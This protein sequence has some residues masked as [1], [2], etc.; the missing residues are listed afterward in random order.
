MSKHQQPSM[1]TMGLIGLGATALGTT[2][3]PD[4][5]FG[6]SLFGQTY[7]YGYDG[8]SETML[9]FLRLAVIAGW[10]GVGFAIGWFISPQAKELRKM[11]L[12]IAVAVAGLVVFFNNGFLGWSLSGFLGLAGFCIG[13]GY[14]LGQT[15]QALGQ[16]PTTFGSAEWAKPEELEE[17]GVFGSEGI[18]LGEANDGEAM[19]P[20]AY[21]GDRHLLTVAPARTG[22]GTSQ[23]VPNLL[24][25][26]GSCVVIDPK[27]ENAMMTAQ[28]RRDMGQQVHLLD[29]WGIAEIEGFEPSRF[30]PMDWLDPGD[31]E[32]TENAMILGDAQIIPSGSAETF[33][34]EE[35]KA[36][37]LGI[38]LYVAT[39][40][41]EAGQRHLGRA[42][43]LMLLDGEDLK[44]LFE[45]MLESPHHIVASTGA[46]AL[47][48]E[49]KLLSNV[50]AS[51]QAQTH[52][53]DSAA[54][55][56]S[57]SVSDF[58]FEDLKTQPMTVYLILPA[59]R[60]NAF[61]RWLR[62]MIQQA[63]TV[64]ARNITDKPDKPVLFILDE[65]AALG[66]LTM[67]EQAY[68]LMAGFGMQLHGVVQD[69][70]QLKRIYGD[71]WETFVGNSGV[72]QYFG[73]RDRMSAEYF[74][75]L[76]G[77]TT[78]WNLS[79]AL[80]RTFSSSSGN[81]GGS[82]SVGN[83][84]TTAAAQRK[85]A[86]PDELMR[87]PKVQQIIFIENMN[88]IVATKVPWFEDDHLKQ[89]GVNLQ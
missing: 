48:K 10:T 66:R 65:M 47:Q 79:S 25:Y 2:L 75:A 53:L 27:G 5:A 57:L 64:N 3:L 76:C 40:E 67:V 72:I 56:D 85:L 78:V 69:L 63:I 35:A 81:G 54:I 18:R 50:L 42:R 12:G 77:E 71:G 32:M 58:K 36:L 46:R 68:G 6:Q 84:D 43:D 16:V 73:S 14:W 19:R 49:E 4:P 23:I 31:V 89:L 24:T 88:P 9:G 33:W 37:N 44:A 87:L 20:I 11:A 29:P 82:N 28:A 83:T 13:L 15:L 74:S 34:D 45:R 61:S 51:L 41:R 7:N 52:F 86:Y 8:P 30:N 1:I 80:S 38:D 70:S 62:L 22:K 21:G 59:D 60:L 39:D 55:R 17:H 26:E